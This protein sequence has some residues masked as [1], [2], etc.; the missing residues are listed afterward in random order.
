MSSSY[1][2]NA[3]TRETSGKNHQTPS[4]KMVSWKIWH[5]RDVENILVGASND[6][7]QRN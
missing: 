4:T 6:F 2:K 7:L 3:R 1:R 5:V